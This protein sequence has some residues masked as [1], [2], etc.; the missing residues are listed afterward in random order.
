MKIENNKV[1]TDDDQLMVIVSPGFGAGWSTWIGV[2]DVD[3]ATDSRIVLARLDSIQ[4]M[5]DT[6][7]LY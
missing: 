4:S 3:V 2:E 6:T 7:I 1:Y 5:I